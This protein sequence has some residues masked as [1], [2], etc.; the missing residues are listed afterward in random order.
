MITILN[1]LIWSVAIYLSSFILWR[2]IRAEYTE[3]ESIS[4]ILWTFL[5]GLL[6]GKVLGIIWLTLQGD[7][8]TQ[9]LWNSE[10]DI[11]G[12]VIGGYITALW[13]HTNNDLWWGDLQ[14]GLMEAVFWATA[15][16]ITGTGLIFSMWDVISWWIQL[17]LYWG[18]LLGVYFVRYTYRSY[19]WYRSG[20]V[21]LTFRLGLIFLVC[22][23]I[24]WASI[25]TVVWTLAIKLLWNLLVLI[26]AL[27]QTYT[28]SGRSWRVDRIHVSQKFHR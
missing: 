8:S 4:L 19:H 12:V 7:I 21:G 15:I 14:D 17:S 3:S 6:F 18:G 5:G 28:L 20:R 9:A 27:W 16:I 13:H 24:I 22:I 23:N 1:W 2:R 26:W 25:S 10:F 11:V